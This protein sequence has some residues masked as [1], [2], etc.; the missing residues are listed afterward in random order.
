MKKIF[1]I[2]CITLTVIT[3]AQNT[4]TAKVLDSENAE[5]LIGASLT[6]KGTTNGVL[7]GIMII[8][9]GSF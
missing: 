2:I 9:Q 5:A 8:N 6:L 4:F 3:N 7:V 1:T